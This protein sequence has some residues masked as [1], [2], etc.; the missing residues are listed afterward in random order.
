MQ[1]VLQGKGKGTRTPGSGGGGGGN[2]PSSRGG[3]SGGGGGPPGGGQP[4]AT[5]QPI[6]PVADVKAMGSLP[7]IFTR[8]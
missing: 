3:P 4:A 8:D 5:Q 1:K 7:Q 6:A 2:P